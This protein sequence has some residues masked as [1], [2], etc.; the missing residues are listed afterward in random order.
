MLQP[1]HQEST[2]QAAVAQ[3]ARNHRGSPTPG[4]PAAPAR[5]VSAAPVLDRAL[6]LWP[7]LDRRRLR[8]TG[9]DPRKVARLIAQ[10]TSMPEDAILRVLEG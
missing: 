10:R 6:A 7:R 1:R 4:A 2:M 9:G 8:R 5:A 3:L